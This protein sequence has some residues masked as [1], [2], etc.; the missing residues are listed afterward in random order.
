MHDSKPQ[1]KDAIVVK[2]AQLNYNIG[3]WIVCDKTY[4]RRRSEFESR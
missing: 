2:K 3:R 1:L 4:V